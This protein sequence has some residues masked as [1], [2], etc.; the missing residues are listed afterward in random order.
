MNL[1]QL[2]TTKSWSTDR[3]KGEEIPGGD[4]PQLP[5]ERL[6][7]WIFLG[8]VTALMSLLVS[9]YLMRMAHADWRPLPEPWQ[10]WLNTALLIMSSIALQRARLG[11]EGGRPG[12]VR[13]MLLVAGCLAF[14]FLAGQ[15]WAWRELEALGYFVAAN[16]ANSFFYLITGLHGLHLLGGL[17]AWLKTTLRAW[18]GNSGAD[19]GLSIGL[20]TLYWHFLLLLWLLL[21]ALLLWT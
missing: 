18:R 20:C 17:A 3:G 10:L 13:V 19:L 2:L 9:A 21:F 16:P 8:V 11:A 14:G 6:G 1:I 7:L 4:Q 5:K 15:L 12:Q